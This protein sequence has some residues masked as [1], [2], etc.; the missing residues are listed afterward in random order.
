MC[1]AQETGVLKLSAQTATKLLKLKPV[2]HE[3]QLS[4]LA[5]T[6]IFVIESVHD[7][8]IDPHPKKSL[9]IK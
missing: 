1:L 7:S 2:V 6:V 4:D 8:E 5:D 3:F 9:Q